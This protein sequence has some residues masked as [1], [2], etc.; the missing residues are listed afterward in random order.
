MKNS[1]VR[2]YS[3]VSWLVFLFTISIVLISLVPVIFPALF[4]ETFFKTELDG[5]GI[6][7]YNLEPFELGG[8]AATLIITNIIVFV[9]FALF[10]NKITWQEKIKS[11]TKFQIS[12]KVALILVVIILIGYVSVSYSDVGFGM[13]IGGH[14]EIYDDWDRLK[15]KLANMQN[16]WPEQITSFDPHFKHILLKISERIFENYFV[17]PFFSSIGLLIIT[18]LFTNKITDSRIAGLLSMLLVLQSNLFLTFDTSAAFASFWTLFYLLSLYFIIKIWPL[19]PVFYVLSI[20]SKILTAFFAPMSIFF[21]LNSDVSKQRKI[22]L[23]VIFLAIIVIG[24]SVSTTQTNI[25]LEWNSD[26]FWL[27]FTAF[28]FQMRLDIIFVIFLLPLTVG[29]FI[30]SKNNRYSNSILI[31]LAGT[32]LSAPLV[33]GLTDMTNQPYRFLP[34]VVFFSVGIGML[35]A[36][37]KTI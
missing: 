17:I 5:F 29:L 16:I 24:I 31:L 23:T 30:I 11:F 12:Q 4:S 14:G 18:Y 35:F 37:R 27:G 28:A 9:I 7:S 36:N 6:T 26:E 13:P 1:E 19:T 34:L 22:I 15:H 8:L 10:K 2:R 21:I 20:L 33:T 32:L 25:G 3:K